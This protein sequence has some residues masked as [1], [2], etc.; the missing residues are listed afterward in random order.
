MLEVVTREK[1]RLW[2]TVYEYKNTVTS[3]NVSKRG[4]VEIKSIMA[5]L[6][7]SQ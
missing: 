3:G 1:E 4:R 7:V 5:D 2:C 6:N